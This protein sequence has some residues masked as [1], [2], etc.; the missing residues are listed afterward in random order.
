[1]TLLAL[2]A[3]TACGPKTPPLPPEPDFG[4]V[5]LAKGAC[6]DP[7]DF[8]ALDPDE[9]EAAR[10]ETLDQVV[11]QWRGGLN[12]GVNFGVD[13]AREVRDLLRDRPQ[14]I[15]AVVATNLVYCM[16]WAAEGVSTMAWGG[17]LE[18]LPEDLTSGECIAALTEDWFGLLSVDRAW[19]HEVLLCPGETVTIEAT[20][21][22][23]YQLGP[24]GP[25]TTVAGLFGQPIPAGAPCTDE[26][27]AWG[28][29]MGRFEAQDGSTTLIAI[30]GGTTFTAPAEGTLSFQVNDDPLRDNV[31]A[32]V[33]GVMDGAMIGVR[34]T[35]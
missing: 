13:L 15:S 25:A 27:C 17:W 5:E 26:G 4:W 35:R 14:R 12:D 28:M 23:E 34:P 8:G 31:W 29:L 20:A 16:E 10:R 3:L 2:S 24:E 21:G 18:S 6:Y 11:L 19:Q 32:V 7:P 30:S 1:M 33:D 9:L 22:S